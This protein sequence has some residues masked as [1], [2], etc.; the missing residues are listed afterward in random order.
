MKL[1]KRQTMQ[2]K[3]GSLVIGNVEIVYVDMALRKEVGKGY[4]GP[5]GGSGGQP[6][7]GALSE[8]GFKTQIWNG[9]YVS[10]SL[11]IYLKLISFLIIF[12]K[13]DRSIC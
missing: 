2:R 4:N 8:A 1:N 7:L 11:I 3:R 10:S 6:K 12:L 5:Q 13:N 9:E